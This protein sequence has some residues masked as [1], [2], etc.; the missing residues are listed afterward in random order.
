MEEKIQSNESG[1]G[2]EDS[3]VINVFSDYLKAVAAERDS[4][5]DAAD[6]DEDICIDCD[7]PF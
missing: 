2:Y 6:A 4:F 1:L 3:P 5:A 7:L